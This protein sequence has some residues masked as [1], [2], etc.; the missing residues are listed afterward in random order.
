MTTRQHGPVERR[1][2]DLARRQLDGAGVPSWAAYDATEIFEPQLFVWVADEG[3]MRWALVGE[4][5]R[6]ELEGLLGRC[7]DER[8]GAVE[9]RP[10]ASPRDF[11]EPTALAR[12][13]ADS[14][15]H[16]PLG[17]S[18][19]RPLGDVLGFAEAQLERLLR[20]EEGA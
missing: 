15:G 7:R 11:G 20:D 4:A 12:I 5:G 18:L 17:R 13:T 8:L 1:E 10:G 14:F 16:G 9:H 6:E 3:G 2:K 19:V